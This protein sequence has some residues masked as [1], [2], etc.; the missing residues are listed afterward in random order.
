MIMLPE[1]PTPE[2]KNNWMSVEVLLPVIV[3]IFMVLFIGRLGTFTLDLAQTIFFGLTALGWFSI[4][5]M[6]EFKHRT[7]KVVLPTGFTTFTG[8]FL[9]NK[10][11]NHGII[12]AGTVR[13]MNV[14]IDEV[15]EGVIIFPLDCLRKTGKCAV[16]QVDSVR[17]AR[18]NEISDKLVAAWLI[19]SNIGEPYYICK[20][21]TEKNLRKP[22]IKKLVDILDNTRAA[23]DQLEK[24]I[25]AK[26]DITE[27]SVA[28]GS[29]IREIATELRQRFD[30]IK[31]PSE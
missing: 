13:A 25:K 15:S 22:D 5:V 8:D 18:I 17:K 29:R 30:K 31:Q 23:N 10:H 21:Y 12:K 19:R 3:L 20:N 4:L 1:E 2:K 9:I 7:R 14:E 28:S 6:D 24:K 26:F 16:L 27:D 11:S